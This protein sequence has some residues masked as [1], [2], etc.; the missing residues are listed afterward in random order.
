[1]LCY[2]FRTRLQINRYAKPLTCRPWN[3]LRYL[4]K[5]QHRATQFHALAGGSFKMCSPFPSFDLDLL[6]KQP[7]ALR[8]KIADGRLL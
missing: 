7:T 3:E 4:V 5:A 6:V 1:M 2:L 8:Y